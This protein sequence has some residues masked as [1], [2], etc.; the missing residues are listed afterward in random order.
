M[1]NKILIGNSGLEFSDKVMKTAFRSP[2]FRAVLRSLMS[3]YAQPKDQEFYLQRLN[4]CLID[5]ALQ[6]KKTK[7]K[8]LAKRILGRRKSGATPVQSTNFIQAF[9]TTDQAR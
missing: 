4:E 9:G 2:R 6:A 7:R 1:T 3:D 8:S 5:I